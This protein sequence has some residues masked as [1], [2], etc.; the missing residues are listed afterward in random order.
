MLVDS[1]DHVLIAD[2]DELLDTALHH[3]WTSRSDRSFV[4]HGLPVPTN[5]IPG[6]PEKIAILKGRQVAGVELHH[7]D[8]ALSIRCIPA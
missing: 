4:P 3:F 2:S 6:T 1:V 8:D 7:P 5:A